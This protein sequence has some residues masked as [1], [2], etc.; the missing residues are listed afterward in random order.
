MNCPMKKLLKELTATT[1]ASTTAAASITTTDTTT[2]AASTTTT[3]AST[4]RKI[5]VDSCVNNCVNSSVDISSG[6]K[7]VNGVTAGKNQCE[8]CALLAFKYIAA[9][10]DVVEFQRKVREVMRKR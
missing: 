2:P 5:S 4:A 10:E 6:K 1:A 8:C 7:D 9:C 3:P